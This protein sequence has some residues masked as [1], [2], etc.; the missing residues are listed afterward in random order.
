MSL[1]FP[2]LVELLIGHEVLDHDKRC[3]VPC[4][5][6]TTMLC[7]SSTDN[8]AH[9]GVRAAVGPLVISEAEEGTS[10]P[11]GGLLTDTR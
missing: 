1:L 2:E 5:P 4:I 11:I 7:S 10:D 9:H 3:Y 6:A 8:S